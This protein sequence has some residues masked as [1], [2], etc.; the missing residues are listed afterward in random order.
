MS[1]IVAIFMG[2]TVSAEEIIKDRK[3]LKREAFLNLSWNSYLMSKVFV[4]FAISA[5]Q[6]F[7]FVLIGNGITEVKGMMFEYWLVLF[8]CWAG[9]NMLG[10]VI[11]DSFK[12][13]V[14]IYILI[15]FLVIPQIILSGV[16]VKFEKLNPN[17]SSPVSIPIY[18]EFITARWGYE[19]LAVKQFMNN[20]YEKP[21][22]LF[23]KEMSKA[24]FKKDYWNVEIK[25]AL[26]NIINS[27][28]K[29]VRDKEFRD[30]LLLVSNEIKKQLV[31]TPDIKFEFTDQITPDKITPDIANAA[32]AYV[33]SIRK[34][35]VNLYNDASNRKEAL[36]S[37]LAGENLQ[38]F[39][40]LRDSYFNKSLEEFVKD[41]N[42][43][44][45]TIIYKGELVQKLDPV[46]MDS[47]YKLIR[48]H[49]YAPEKQ[50]FGMKVDTYVVNVIVL[51]IMTFLLY[52][53]LY[54]RL[55]KKLLDS[56]EDIFGKKIKNSD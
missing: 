17:I 47:K 48:A 26:D 14:T 39:L 12:A 29:G 44:T 52:L 50:V 30:N 27:L 6:A 51:W 38:K 1:V 13:V 41:K 28:D 33:E 25:G 43:T 53:A 3:I 22:Y 11:S 32:I 10:L 31:L 21:F 5:I 35:Y 46:F 18:G 54:F 16:M 45:K 4:Q 42:E 55:L 15:P 9:A 24:T 40:K 19:A 56:G 7:T 20:N 49:F 36:K 2:L 8:S 37:R 34:L 23:E